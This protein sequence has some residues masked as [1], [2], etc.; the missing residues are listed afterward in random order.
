MI[1]FAESRMERKEAD[2]KESIWS[3]EIFDIVSTS[4]C[5]IFEVYF[6]IVPLA[7]PQKAFLYSWSPEMFVISFKEQE[8]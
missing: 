3:R 2:L 5:Q 8:I 6:Y 7:S 1:H 4:L